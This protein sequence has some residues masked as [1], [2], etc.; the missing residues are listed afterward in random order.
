M[1]GAKQQ[2]LAAQQAAVNTAPVEKRTLSAMISQD[3]MLTYRA[4]ADGSRYSV[5]NQAHGTTYT[6]LPGLGRVIAQGHMLYRVNDRPV[7]L[8][9]GSTPAYRA[10]SEG[11]TG[12][13]S[14]SSTGTCRQRSTDSA[15]TCSPSAT[16]R[17]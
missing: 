7:V 2:A 6:E 9:Q 8:L 5:I 14:P 12:P 13:T 16:A 10:L 15:P 11:A 4:R 1:F 3:G 17:A